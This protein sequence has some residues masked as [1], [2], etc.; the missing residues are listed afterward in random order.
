MTRVRALLAKDLADLRQNPGIFFPA[1]LTGTI[2]LV[3]PL[4]VAVM[5]WGVVGREERYLERKFGSVYR[6]YKATVRRWL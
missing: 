5:N 3:L 2:S 1:L 6:D 4:V